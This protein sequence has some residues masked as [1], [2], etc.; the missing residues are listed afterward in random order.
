MI[1]QGLVICLALFA[2]SQK[3]APPAAAP[4]G[5]LP[6][7]DDNTAQMPASH[8][9]D[10]QLPAGH[11]QLPAGHPA[12]PSGSM[13]AGSM[14]EGTENFDPS[15]QPIDPTKI[16]AG[17]IELGSKVRANVKPDDIIFLSVRQSQDGM[18]GQILAVDRFTAKAFP[19]EFLVDGHKAMVPGTD[20][21]GKVIISARVDKD[22]DAMTKNP[23][24]VEGKIVTEIPN[25][26]VVVTLD[27]V[28]Q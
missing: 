2:C 17:K 9:S 4:S 7:L 18:P 8:G 28:L 21:K 5:G 26:R 24:D 14:G 13:G 27:T 12:V 25:K 20:F 10:P 11:P 23:G 15:A 1:R 3:S 19:I 22:G 16:L 6:P